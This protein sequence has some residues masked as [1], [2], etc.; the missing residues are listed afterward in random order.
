MFVEVC[1]KY[2]INEIYLI[3]YVFLE[4][5][6]GISNFVNGKD[7]VYNYFGIGVYDN[8]FNYVMMFV[9]NKGWIFLVKVIMGGVSFVRK[10]YINKG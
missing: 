10:D 5:G 1:K 9:R 2:N 6:Y 3:V 4:S 7:G 8:N